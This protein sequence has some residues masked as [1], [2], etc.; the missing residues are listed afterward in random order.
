LPVILVDSTGNKDS[1]QRLDQKT[2]TMRILLLFTVVLTINS[3]A[4]EAFTSI[5]GKIFDKTSKEPTPYASIYINGKSIGTTTNDEGKFLFHVPSGFGK[6]TL[7]VSVIGYDHFKSPVNVMTEKK[8][9]IELKQSITMLNEITV[10]ISKKELTG[11]DIVKK[12]VA[13]IPEN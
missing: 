12:A 11:K 1:I 4:Q 10:S 8:N 6:D 5:E 3:H 9:V 13:R 2:Q 7:I